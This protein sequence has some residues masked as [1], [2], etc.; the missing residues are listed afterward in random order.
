[1]PKYKGVQKKGNR[2][3]WYLNYRGKRYYD[4]GGFDSA[5]DAE[6]PEPFFYSFV[7]NLFT[8]KSR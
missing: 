8:Q 4:R 1:M 2:Y 6:K 7:K 3:Y 5:E